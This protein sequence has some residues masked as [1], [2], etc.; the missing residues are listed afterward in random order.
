MNRTSLGP[1][2]FT[3]WWDPRLGVS[4]PR[5]TSGARVLTPSAQ[6]ASLTHDD[7]DHMPTPP[8]PAHIPVRRLCGRLR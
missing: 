3:R 6:N 8:A 1:D 7:D 4:R 2:I 5:M